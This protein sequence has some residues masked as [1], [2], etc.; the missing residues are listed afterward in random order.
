[1]IYPEIKAFGVQYHPEMM[2]KATDAHRFFFEM[3]YDIMYKS[4]KHFTEI[5]TGTKK[6]YM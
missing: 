3:A 5:Y 4:V 1:V 2:D 6:A